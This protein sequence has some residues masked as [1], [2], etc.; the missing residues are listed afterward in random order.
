MALRKLIRRNHGG[1]PPVIIK[2]HNL[3]YFQEGVILLCETTLETRQISHL[4][5]S[6]LFTIPLKLYRYSNKVIHQTDKMS[7]SS[8]AS[9][10]KFYGKMRVSFCFNTRKCLFLEVLFLKQQK[11]NR[12]L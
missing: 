9:F 8:Y 4:N 6:P 10:N 11:E 12:F 3:H 5:S 7:A 2:C 1:I